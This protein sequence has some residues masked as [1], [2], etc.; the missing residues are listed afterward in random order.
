MLSRLTKAKFT[1]QH[2]IFLPRGVVPSFLRVL[3]APSSLQGQHLPSCEGRAFRL[4]E[5][6]FLNLQGAFLFSLLPEGRSFLSSSPF[7]DLIS[8]G[9][10]QCLAYSMGTIV[11]RSDHGSK[12]ILIMCIDSSVLLV[13]YV[14]CVY[15]VFLVPFFAIFTHIHTSTI[16][17]SF[18]LNHMPHPPN[19]RLQIRLQLPPLDTL[20]PTALP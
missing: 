1:C 17:S 20:L 7:S 19:F 3:F 9:S 16:S 2:H 4:L 8:L 13:L 6:T 12:C 15:P 11:E 10:F 5:I 14:I 18:L